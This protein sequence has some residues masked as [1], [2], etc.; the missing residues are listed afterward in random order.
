MDFCQQHLFADNKSFV[1]GKEMPLVKMISLSK[2][3]NVYNFDINFETIRLIL[4][5]YLWQLMIHAPH[6]SLRTKYS[7]LCKLL[8]DTCQ[9][10]QLGDKVSMLN[11]TYPHK[12]VGKIKVSICNHQAD[13]PLYVWLRSDLVICK[14]RNVWS[15]IWHWMSLLRLD[16]IKQPKPKLKHVKIGIFKLFSCSD[17]P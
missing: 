17:G 16:D 1:I 8:H 9:T 15:Y 14:F 4:Y 3:Y 7:D 13:T 2:R 5:C 11:H 10:W 6:T 12:P